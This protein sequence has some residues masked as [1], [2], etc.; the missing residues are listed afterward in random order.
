[1]PWRWDPI[2]QQAFD[3]LMAAMR[4]GGARQKVPLRVVFLTYYCT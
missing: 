2:H 3:N 4:L 1:M